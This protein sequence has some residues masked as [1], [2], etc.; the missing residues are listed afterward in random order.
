MS[1]AAALDSVVLSIIALEEAAVHRGAEGGGRCVGMHTS[2]HDRV[3]AGG[4]V[5]ENQ[6]GVAKIVFESSGLL[7]YYN[8]DL[9]DEAMVLVV[10]VAPFDFLVTACCW[11]QQHMGRRDV[12]AKMADSQLPSLWSSEAVGRIP[13]SVWKRSPRMGLR[14]QVLP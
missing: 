10:A 12:V 1:L 11:V 3:V 9:H 7:V 13:V 6:T 8:D 2:D 14:Q 5:M 4:H